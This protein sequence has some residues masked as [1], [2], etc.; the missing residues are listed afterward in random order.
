MG[1]DVAEEP[2]FWAQ[3]AL[4]QTHLVHVH[5]VYF[6]NL[7]EIDIYP[8]FITVTLKGFKKRSF[9]LSYLRSFEIVLKIRILLD[10]Y[11]LDHRL[12]KN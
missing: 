10:L 12:E 5:G 3:Q 4:Y 2:G 8:P 9:Y 1:P 11:F 7:H 6:L